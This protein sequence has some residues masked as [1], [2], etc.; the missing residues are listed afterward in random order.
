LIEST[1]YFTGNPKRNNPINNARAIAMKQTSSHVL[2]ESETIV[3]SLK[4]SAM[5]ILRQLSGSIVSLHGSS[6]GAESMPRADFYARIHIR[7]Y[8]NGL[9]CIAIDRQPASIIAT[10]MIMGEPEDIDRAILVDAIGEIANQIAGKFRTVINEFGGRLEIS[11]PAIEEKPP[12]THMMQMEGLPT[13]VVCLRVDEYCVA[14]ALT[15]E[16]AAGQ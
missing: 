16:F 11:T 10:R 3:H 7:G 6:F 9:I 1:I 2:V 13:H 15:A 5:T 4:H 8:L 12:Y 14:V